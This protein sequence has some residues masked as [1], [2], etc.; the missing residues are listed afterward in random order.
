MPIIRSAVNDQQFKS[1]WISWIGSSQSL[2]LGYQIE[3]GESPYQ[4]ADTRLN[5]VA[6]ACSSSVLMPFP[7]PALPAL[8]APRPPGLE[9]GLL[10][11]AGWPDARLRR[12]LIR[13]GPLLLGVRVVERGRAQLWRRV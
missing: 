7:P 12:R 9:Q 3:T 2:W 6:G 13:Q 5:Q 10:L 1:A 8:P 4:Q 11:L